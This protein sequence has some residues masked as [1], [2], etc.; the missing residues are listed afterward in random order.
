MFN[1]YNLLSGSSGDTGIGPHSQIG[2]AGFCFTDRLASG[3]EFGGARRRQ[4]RRAPFRP[5]PDLDGDGSRRVRGSSVDIG[6]FEYGDHSCMR[7]GDPEPLRAESRL[8][9]RALGG[10]APHHP[11]RRRRR[12]AVANDRPMS[13]SYDELTQRWNLR[14]DDGQP[15]GFGSVYALFQPE[16]SRQCRH[17]MSPRP[18]P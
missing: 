13:Q 5:M 18:A 12:I 11:F 3:A 16:R 8:A 4:P 10:A 2:A 17:P 9:E 6:A 15:L 1:D 7:T 14:S